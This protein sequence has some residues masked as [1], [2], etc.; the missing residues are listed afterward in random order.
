MEKAYLVTENTDFEKFKNSI[1]KYDRIYFWDAYCE[2][3]LMF[4]INDENFINK[5]F[6]F[7]K[8][9]TL[10]TPIISEKNIGNLKSFIEK[11]KEEKWFEVVVNDYWVFNIIKKLFPSIKIIRWNFLSWQSKDPFLKVFKDKETH[12]KISI[13]ND[14]YSDYLN[15]NF[16]NMIEMYNT[17][18]WFD[19]EKDFEISI[20]FPYVV[21]SINRYCPTK[22]IHDNKNYLTVVED[23]DWCKWKIPKNFNMELKMKQD[24]S[25]NFFRWNKQFYENEKLIEHKNIKR[26]IYNYDLL[27]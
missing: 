7:K 24:S 23:C 25:K 11:A 17:F 9:L 10:T 12:T 19:I 22:L 3:N 2:H 20:Y 1:D 18:Q 14:F 21:Y 13:D 4:F 26:I 8:P 6:S 16:I 15:K 5:L 27:W